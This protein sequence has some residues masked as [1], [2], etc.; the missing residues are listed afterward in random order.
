M[1]HEYYYKIYGL[2]VRCGIPLPGA[3]P[4]EPEENVDVTAVLG[5]I[6]EFLKGSREKGYGTWTNGFINAWFY[7][8][9][10]AEFYI[11]K[12]KTVIIS[13]IE[14]PNWDLMASLFLSAAMSLIMLQ[15]NEAVFHGSCLTANHQAF[16]VSGESGAGKS[17]VSFELMKE[18]YGFLADD[19]VR[20]HAVNGTFVAEPSYPQQKVC[21][22]M[23]LRMGLQLEK[24]RYIDEER[25]KFAK[26]CLDRYVTKALPLKLIIILTKDPKAEKVTCRELIGQDYLTAIVN[27]FYLQNTYRNT[28]GFPA[29][30]MMQLLAMASQVKV[31]TV[32]RPEAGNTIEQVTDQIRKLVSDVLDFSPS[33]SESKVTAD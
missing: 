14:N 11:E 20:V 1:K 13:P 22:D 7:T 12:G 9:G 25:D 6:P 23:A 3:L 28:T 30:L 16:I 27:A 26:M 8:A 2:V 31:Y 4:C 32:C 19:T 29:E 21:R 17:T 5:E 15:R 18:P 24:L 33:V 10:A